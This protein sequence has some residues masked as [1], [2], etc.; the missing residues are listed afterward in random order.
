MKIKN[1][2][3]H[4]RPI[5]NEEKKIY[6]ENDDACFKFD[7]LDSIENDTIKGSWSIQLDPTKKI[8]N[9]RSLLWPGYYA[10]HLS[11]SDLYGGVYFGNGK[12]N[13]DL[14]FMI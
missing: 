14:P 3:L 10:V 1:K 12:K 2:F 9:V 8:C 6:V 11:N 13:Y 7:I 4:F 5:M